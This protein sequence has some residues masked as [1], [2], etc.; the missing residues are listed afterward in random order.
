MKNNFQS[1]LIF[2]P[3]PNFKRFRN[4]M[5]HIIPDRIPF[6]EF[7]I[8]KEIKEAVIGRPLITIEDDIEFFYIAGYDYYW[9]Y[10]QG[11]VPPERRKDSRFI[12][13]YGDNNSSSRS[14]GNGWI[15]NWEEFINYPWERLEEIDFM[16]IEEIKVLLP[17]NMKVIINIGPFFSGVWRTMSITN[18]SYSLTNDISLVEAIVNKIG[19]SLVYISENVIKFDH[20]QGILLGDDLAFSEGLMVSPDFLRK[21][22]FPTEKKIGELVHASKKLF[23]RHSDGKLYDIMDDLIEYCRYDALNPFEPKAMDIDY[24]KKKWGKKVAIIGNI[25]VDLLIRGT[26]EEIKNLTLRRLKTLGPGGGFALGSS[27]SIESHTKIENYAMMLNT[28][29][30]YGRYPINVS[31]ES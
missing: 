3:S 24:V 31:L 17:D 4:A 27:N 5:K 22:I 23:I 15:A 28:L 8:D 13:R 11:C 2:K 6:G 14:T 19:E 10:I 20:V 12:E 21:F 7:T 26:P 18:F 9:F 29:F 1:K 16:K 30:E 25:D